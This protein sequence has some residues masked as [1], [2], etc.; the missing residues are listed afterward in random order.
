MGRRDFLR[1]LKRGQIVQATV[2]ELLPGAQV[3][4]SFY[5]ELLRI[6]NHTGTAMVEGQTIRL[7]VKGTQPLEFQV[8]DPRTP[9]FE[10][11]V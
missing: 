11:V 5:G 2:E 6:N 1:S 3:I 8:F 10:R 7:Q 4:C 9:K